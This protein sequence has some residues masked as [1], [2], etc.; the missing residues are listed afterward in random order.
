M[1]SAIRALVLLLVAAG[2]AQAS[3]VCRPRLPPGR[4]P[5]LESRCTG[6]VPLG[7]KPRLPCSM[8]SDLFNMMQDPKDTGDWNW[9]A[10]LSKP[11]PGTPHTPGF[12]PSWD[13][14]DFGSNNMP[15]LAAAIALWAP[16]L[17]PGFEPVAWW[18][19]FLRCQTDHASCPYTN[20]VQWM[21]GH[22]L[23]SPIYDPPVVTAVVAVNLWANTQSGGAAS[24]LG[25]LAETYLEMSSALYSLAALDTQVVSQKHTDFDNIAGTGTCPRAPAC[26]GPGSHP[27]AH[28]ERLKVLPCDFS[29]GQPTW[30]GPVMALAGAR[31]QAGDNCSKDGDPWLARA[32]DWPGVTVNREGTEQAEILDCAESN[33][34]ATNPRNPYGN[35]ADRRALLR[36][37][38]KGK[39][40]DPQALA[41]IL[42]GARFI[43]EYRFL[44]WG[45]SRATVLSHNP[46]TCGQNAKCTA[47][48]FA[49]KV[50]SQT[51]Q[52]ELVYPW[53]LGNQRSCVTTGYAHLLPDAAH[54]TSV[55]VSNIDPSLGEL[56]TC[57]HGQIIVNMPFEA[58]PP[59]FQV[60]IGPTADAQVISGTD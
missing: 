7:A 10:W 12:S 13:T 9:Q 58:S 24:G 4:L 60:V 40:Y 36:D 17:A 14:F 29:S 59:L 48:A 30:N 27:F 49:A 46:E 52:L 34:P 50:S 37:H 5:I 25:P 23:M 55:E 32:I 1:R 28:E 19:A 20:D 2:A 21:K 8:E 53:T 43:D 31:S 35:D 18:K 44:T 39:P 38:I 22:E 11:K 54:P 42:K 57:N 33:W 41:Q 16:K 6:E 3:V 26:T 47:A 15:V 56:P 45:D 51:H